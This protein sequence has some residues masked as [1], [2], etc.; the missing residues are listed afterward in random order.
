MSRPEQ[1]WK[2]EGQRGGLDCATGEACRTTSG[3]ER[4]YAQ[5]VR[6]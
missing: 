2:V 1:S 5:P 4:G 3:V 6:A